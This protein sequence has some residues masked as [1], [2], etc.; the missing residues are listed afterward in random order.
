[1]RRVDTDQVIREIVHRVSSRLLSLFVSLFHRPG[2]LFVIRSGRDCRI[3]S[4]IASSRVTTRRARKSEYAFTHAFEH[5]PVIPL[6]AR[7]RTVRES[8]LDG[9]LMCAFDMILERGAM[10]ED[11]LAFDACV[12][13]GNHVQTIP[14]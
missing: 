14:L 7:D 13:S 10:W 11:V 9:V 1:M 4:S 6:D 3:V 5:A 12:R 8:D 2:L